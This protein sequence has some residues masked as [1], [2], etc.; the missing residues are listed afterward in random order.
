MD[1]YKGFICSSEAQEDLGIQGMDPMQNF[2][3][4]KQHLSA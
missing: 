3:K 2:L 1:D 4:E